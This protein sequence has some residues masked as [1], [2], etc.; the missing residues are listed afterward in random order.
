MAWAWVYLA[1]SVAG[2]LLVANAFRPLRRPLLL[3]P[4]F[5]AGWYTGEM[6]VWHIVWQVAATIAFGARGCAAELAGLGR[7]RGERRV[8]DGTGRARPD[9]PQRPARLRQRRGREPARP[10][11]RGSSFPGT[12][13]RPCGGSRASC[14]PCPGPPAR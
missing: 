5:F 8:M 7:P 10:S 2:A 11:P 4:S 3:V 1:V 9:L 12:E 6:P 13:A 14:T